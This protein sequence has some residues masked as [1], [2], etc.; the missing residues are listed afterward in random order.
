MKGTDAY[1]SSDS[2]YI[3]QRAVDLGHVA[4]QTKS[5]VLCYLVNRVILERRKEVCS[6]FCQGRIQTSV[7]IG[8]PFCSVSMNSKVFSSQQRCCL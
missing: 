6:L 4:F 3:Y 5:E 8:I 1:C 7:F 2:K